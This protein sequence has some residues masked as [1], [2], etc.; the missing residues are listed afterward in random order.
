MFAGAFCFS[1][2]KNED[3]GKSNDDYLKGNNTLPDLF[4][5]IALC[6]A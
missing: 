3:A 4:A 1:G 5:G 2:E 6:F